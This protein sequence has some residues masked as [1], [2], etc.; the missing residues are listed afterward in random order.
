[1]NLINGMTGEVVD[2]AYKF[3][4]GARTHRFSFKP[5]GGDSNS[6]HFPDILSDSQ[7]FRSEYDTPLDYKYRELIER[8][9]KINNFD[10][11][12]AITTHKAQGSQWNNL[13]VYYEHIYK[14][15]AKWSYT[16]I[17]RAANKLIIAI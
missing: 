12:Y 4:G 7:D 15:H 3:N 11:G 10:Y 13:F 9:E 8:N 5:D 1:M 2:P 14:Q 16:A 17:T 6:P